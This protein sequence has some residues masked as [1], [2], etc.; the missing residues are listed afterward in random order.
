MYYI[1]ITV[2]STESNSD[3]KVIAHIRT[4]TGF[5][6]GGGDQLR[7]I[8]SFYNSHSYHIP[9]PALIAIKETL[10]FT[11]GVIAGT[12]AGT[13]CLTSNLMISGGDSY[14]GLVYG[15]Q[16][17]WEPVASPDIRDL[18]GYSNGLGL[19]PYGLL[20]THFENRGRQGRLL[21][22]L[23]DTRGYPTGSRV[24]FGV[25]ENTALVVTGGEGGSREGRV[26]GERGVMM[27]DITHAS[28]SADGNYWGMRDVSISHLTSGDVLHLAT[29][30]VTPAGYKSPMS[31]S[32]QERE[33]V[34][35]YDIFASDGGVSG[36]RP[37]VHSSAP[38]VP[39]PALFEFDRVARELFES[40]A[41]N[42]TSFTR[43]QSPVQYK[44]Y[45]GKGSASAGYSG[46]DPSTNAASFSYSNLVVHMTI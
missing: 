20:D 26:I 18:T 35:S 12:S 2:N 30:T 28:V 33:V 44:V 5:M 39:A 6:F 29:Y 24:A 38:A 17:Y 25:D 27:I 13:D 15:S 22:L 32:E 14:H 45:M 8:Q 43:E 1:P 9:S 21:R 31:L 4:L 42:T 11:G 40:T 23:M 36:P 41:T 46:V 37:V 16:V 34:P 19:F 10:L 7:I 3:E